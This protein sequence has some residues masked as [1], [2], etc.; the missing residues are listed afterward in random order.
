M[1]NQYFYDLAIRSANVAH[2]RGMTNID[3]NW[4][5]AQWVHESTD[6][7]SELATDNHNLGGVT[8][9]KPNDTPQPDGK[10]FYINFNSYE[11]YADYFGKYLHGFIDG[12]V[13]VATTLTEYVT[14][15]K[16]SPSGEYFGDSLDN[17]LTDC[18][19]IYDG[20]F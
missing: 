8:Q 11:A 10:Q 14:A 1:I 5:Y 13:D 9:T 7:T 2:D 17:Y 6:F 20:L 15:L 12:G 16:N 4:I 3:P 19:R 18:Q